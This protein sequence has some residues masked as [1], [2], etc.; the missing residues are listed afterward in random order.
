MSAMSAR[1]H[2]FGEIWGGP[3]QFVHAVDAFERG[4]SAGQVLHFGTRRAKWGDKF[5]E[6][7][8]V[9]GGAAGDRG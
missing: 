8:A 6:N 3:R 4:R 7:G 5:L 2:V 9:I 1:R